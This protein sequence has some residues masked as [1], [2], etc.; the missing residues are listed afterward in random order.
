MIEEA[1]LYSLRVE[2]DSVPTETFY[3]YNS[4]GKDISLDST[5]FFE[6]GKKNLSA[7]RGSGNY[8]YGG[9]IY[10]TNRDVFTKYSSIYLRYAGENFNDA[11]EYDYVLEYGKFTENPE[12]FDV[13]YEV[14]LKKGKVIGSV[15]NTVG[16]LFQVDNYKNYEN[17]SYRLTIKKGDEVLYS[18]SPVLNIVDSPTLANA[19]LKANSKNLYLQTSDQAYIATRNAPID[20]VISGLGFDEDTDYDFH[21]CYYKNYADG[22]WSE[23]NQKCE[24][25]KINGKDLNDGK[26]KIHFNEKIEDKAIS[27]D[28]YVACE[29]KDAYMQ[30]VAIQGGFGVTFVDS[31]EF[32]PNLTKYFV[33][34]VS[35]L[36]KNIS[37]NTSVEDFTSN[38]AV[39]DNGKVIIYDKTGTTEITDNVGTGM[40]ARVK[41]EYDE[42]VLDLDVVVKGDVSGDGN[43]SITD[44]VT[45]K[46]HLAKVETLTGV[47][48]VAGNV[49]DTGKM[50]PTDLVKIARD[51]AKIQEVK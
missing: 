4:V 32:F 29:L 28:F 18:S 21:F 1:E 51:V 13:V 3:K 7:F 42:T 27:Y 8:F 38:I 14:E 17:P 50:G 48:E 16:L 40:I 15:L 43:I 19:S 26:A 23:E 34:N 31:K 47:Y 9:G 20:I 41:N 11:E 25:V 39:K 33:D 35:D 45:V 30:N 49:T 22:S 5:I 2:I 6:N 24:E 37:K 44:L 12:I 10:D 36:I 46:R